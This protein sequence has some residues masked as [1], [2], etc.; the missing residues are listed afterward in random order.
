M[1]ELTTERNE[2]LK[3]LEDDFS[4]DNKKHLT[5]CQKVLEKEIKQSKKCRFEDD[6]KTMNYRTNASHTHR[7]ISTINEKIQERSNEAINQNGKILTSNKA[8]SKA[9]LNHYLKVSSGKSKIRKLKPQQKPEPF[10][11]N[12]LQDAAKMMEENKAPGP[13]GIQ[14]EFIKHLDT[15]YDLVSRDL[16]IEKLIKMNI[17]QISSMLLE[18]SYVNY[19]HW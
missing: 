15:A 9:F 14:F 13:D 12:E 7:R 2:A 16:V 17:H 11:F 10:T 5:N 19:L 8:K 1:A 4:N 6:L 18:T 3:A